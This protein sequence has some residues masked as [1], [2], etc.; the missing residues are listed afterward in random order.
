MSFTFAEAK[1]QIATGATSVSVTLDGSVASGDLLVMI[2]RTSDSAITSGQISDD[3]GNT[4]TVAGTQNNVSIAYVLSSAAH[5]GTCNVT[6]TASVSG[7]MRVAVQRWATGGAGAVF[8]HYVPHVGVAGTSGNC[9]TITGEAAGL[10]CIAGGGASASNVTYTAGSTN[11]VAGTIPTGG[12]TTSPA[13]GSIFSEYAFPTVAGDQ[14]FTYTSDVTST[15]NGGTIT[16]DVAGQTLVP[17]ADVATGSWT[18]STG[19]TLFGVI[20]ESAANDADYIQSSSSPATADVC[21]VRLAGGINP[22]VATG[23]VVHY[24]YLK[25]AAAGDRIDLTVTF[26]AADGTTVIASWT[27]TDI[28]T[29][30]QADQTLTTTQAGNIPSADYATGLILGFSAIKV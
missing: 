3:A 20:D 29:I 11:S 19:T 7:Q 12:Q 26:Y 10:L 17:V 25:S 24:R 5:S 8:K 16:F 23:H 30:T 21:K 27:H 4:W 9:G 15:P 6:A 22:G 1:S 14:T 2:V 13:T 28:G 18:P